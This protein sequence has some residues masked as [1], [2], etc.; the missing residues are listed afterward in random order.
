M[1][2]G[3]CEEEPVGTV[4]RV[5]LEPSMLDGPAVRIPR[6]ADFHLSL[7]DTPRICLVYKRISSGW[8]MGLLLKSHFPYVCSTEVDGDERKQVN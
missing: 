8:S 7:W 6:S 3:Q 1:L 5:P 4:A 2:F